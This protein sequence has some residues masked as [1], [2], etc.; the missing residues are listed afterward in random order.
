MGISEAMTIFSNHDII[1]AIQFAEEAHRDQ[2]RK[3]SNEPYLIHLL[4]VAKMVSCATLDKALELQREEII[5]AAILHDV[6]EDTNV[7]SEDIG[8]AFG[9]SICRIVQELTD[10]PLVAGNREKRKGL[11]RERLRL[12]CHATK[13]IKCADIIDNVHSIVACDP[14]FAKVFLEEIGMLIPLLE[15]PRS[16]L[17]RELVELYATSIP[18]TTDAA[19]GKNVR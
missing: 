16:S 7:T 3:Y 9:S 6:V 4:S 14:K 2:K 19:E 17:H 18:R 15:T 8:L 1:H 12:S 10:P 13:I 11:S 5:I